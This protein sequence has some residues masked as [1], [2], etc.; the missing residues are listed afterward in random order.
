LVFLKIKLNTGL[1]TNILNSRIMSAF[2]TAMNNYTTTWNNAISYATPD[3]SRETDGRVSLFFKT[4]RG[5]DDARLQEYLQKA[6]SED[7]V[8]TFILA[9]NARDC[10]GGKGERSIGRKALRW[11]GINFPDIF[12]D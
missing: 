4:V 1:K 2:S 10:R 5:L 9:F 12:G 3:L 7:L 11:L 8:D 6:S